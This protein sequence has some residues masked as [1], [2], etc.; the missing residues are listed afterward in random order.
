MSKFLKNLNELFENSSMPYTDILVQ[1]GQN[2]RIYNPGGWADLGIPV[3][4]EELQQFAQHL[5]G[6]KSIEALCASLVEH[7]ACNVG[8]VVS[9]TRIRVDVSLMTGAGGDVRMEGDGGNIYDSIQVQPPLL[10]LVIRRH[11]EIIPVDRHR[12][13]PQLLQAL[14]QRSGLI[15]VTGQ[16]GSGKTSTCASL[17]DWIN[18]ETQSHIITIQDPIEHWHEN[19][20]SVFSNKEVGKDVPSF[21]VAAYNALRQRP[22]VIFISELRDRE[23][24]EQALY[25]AQSSLVIAT[26]HAPCL[27]EGLERVLNFFPKEEI[28]CYRSLRSSLRCVIAQALLPSD[29]NQGFTMFYEYVSGSNVVMQECLNNGKGFAPLRK[30]LGTQTTFLTNPQGSDGGTDDIKKQMVGLVPMNVALIRAVE[31]DIVEL[32]DARRASPDLQGFTTAH[33]R[34]PAKGVHVAKVQ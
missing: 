8:C 3:E 14:K 9:N 15:L 21:S 31:S 33:S 16:A 1:D 2:I 26:T 24:C 29:K 34:A 7:G 12:F 25:A 6:F 5:T 18:R 30:A 27:E 28:A 23:T 20:Q 17:L 13:P 11:G 4:R 19:Q 32:V 10:E 22:D